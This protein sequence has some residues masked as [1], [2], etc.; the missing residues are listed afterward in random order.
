M[1]K[2]PVGTKKILVAD[3]SLT[4]QK[5]I[6][7]ALSSEGYQIEAVS[8]GNTALEQISLARPDVVLV[9]LSLPGKSAVEIKA[10]VDRLRRQ[11]GDLLD[12]RFVL[13]SSAFEKV[14]ESQ[15]SQAQFDGHLTK[16]FDPAN[17]RQVLQEVLQ[18]GGGPLHQH[19][20]IPVDE[21]EDTALIEMDAPTPDREQEDPLDLEPI[22]P[23]EPLQE[24]SLDPPQFS[25]S[26]FLPPLSDVGE[27]SSGPTPPP[28]PAAAR[29]VSDPDSD[30]RSLTE[31]TIR[32]SGLDEFQWTIDEKAQKKKAAIESAPA[33]EPD[34]PPPP[35]MAD[36]GGSNFELDGL[37]SGGESEQTAQFGEPTREIHHHSSGSNGANGSTGSA[38][39]VSLDGDQLEQIVQKQVKETLEKLAREILPDVAER[40]IKEE[41]SRLLNERT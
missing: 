20:S 2:N 4:I 7:L 29:T 10:E 35:K 26:S 34:L 30:I 6:R 38:E 5:V 12:V 3:D 27:R 1:V 13:M 41:I 17:L 40:V 24:F 25:E 14:D 39:V 21:D 33:F 23:E 19:A 18:S 11:Q 36:L 37:I 32:M 16:P 8:D 22:Q 31:S 9:D 28:A 15:L